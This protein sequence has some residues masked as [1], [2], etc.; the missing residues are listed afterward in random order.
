MIIINPC[1]KC[2]STKVR[3]SSDHE[4]VSN[5]D[6]VSHYLL[7]CNECDFGVIGTDVPNVV[8]TW[9]A[10]SLPVDGLKEIH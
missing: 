3:L 10:L 1:H 7:K 6:I 8:R 5:T 9:N 2:S 4:E